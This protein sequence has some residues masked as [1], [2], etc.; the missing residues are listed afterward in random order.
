M[1][2]TN[3]HICNI[4]NKFDHSKSTKEVLELAWKAEVLCRERALCVC[5]CVC[6]HMHMRMHMCVE[7][8]C[9]QQDVCFG[10]E[11][12]LFHWLSRGV[13]VMA[14]SD[15]PGHLL[16]FLFVCFD[17]TMWHAELP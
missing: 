9:P 15:G 16:L 6:V 8:T 11:E 2:Y 12:S 1:Y 14:P 5:A 17:R 3:I 7:A 13:I 4:L 10:V